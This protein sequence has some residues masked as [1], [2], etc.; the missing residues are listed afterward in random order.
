MESED[1]HSTRVAELGRRA[2][3][4]LKRRAEQVLRL[5]DWWTGAESQ[6]GLVCVLVLRLALKRSV[7]GNRN[8]LH[9][10]RLEGT[11]RKTVGFQ[12]LI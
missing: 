6:L 12:H 10:C 1:K 5:G 3:V 4:R 11:G 9:C 8:L 2:P 7:D